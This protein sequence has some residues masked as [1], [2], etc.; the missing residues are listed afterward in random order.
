MFKKLA[1]DAGRLVLKE[2]VEVRDGDD[3]SLPDT[4]YW[5][6]TRLAAIVIVMNSSEDEIDIQKYSQLCKDVSVKIVVTFG[7]ARMSESIHRILA[8]SPELIQSNNNRGLGGH[9]E[10]VS[11][12][13]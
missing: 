6:F 1:S 3:P 10:E 11:A 8:H 4:F 5:I 9:S 12:L 13:S 7:W 2:M